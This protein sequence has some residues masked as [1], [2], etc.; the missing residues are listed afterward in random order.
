MTPYAAPLR[1]PHR[2]KGIA[3]GDLAVEFRADTGKVVLSKGSSKDEHYTIQFGQ[4]SGVL[5]LH[6]T[7]RDE[8]GT[9]HHKTLFA[10][11]RED[12]PKLLREL[13]PVTMELLTLRRLRLGWLVRHEIDIARGLDPATVE[14]IAAVTTKNARKRLIFDEEKI[15]AQIRILESVGDIWDFPDGQFSLIK[16]RRKIGVGFKLT[17]QFGEPWL[18]W[19]KLRGLLRRTNGVWNDVV[20]AAG[21]YAI[22]R[23]KYHSCDF[24]V[25]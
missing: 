23:E 1:M 14:E 2:A 13:S 20:T 4:N 5:D 8:S 25:P 10:M 7:W 6:R 3:L 21:R 12:I 15:R 24:L 17:D 18:Y 9:E 16:G 11:L 19:M 22:P